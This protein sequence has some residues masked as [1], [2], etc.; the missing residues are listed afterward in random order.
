[1]TFMQ[2]INAIL[3]AAAVAMMLPI[4]MFCLECLAAVLPRCRRRLP[5]PT[6]WNGDGSST[7]DSAISASGDASYNDQSA[8]GNDTASSPL[9]KG[10]TAG[11]SSSAGDIMREKHCWTSQQWRPFSQKPTFSTGC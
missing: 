5:S 8:P 11:L 7:A 10:A 9:K 6:D 2:S 3:L 4:G 1:M